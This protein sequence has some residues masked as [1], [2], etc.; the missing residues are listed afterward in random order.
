MCNFF[1]SLRAF[2]LITARAPSTWRQLKNLTL[3]IDRHPNHGKLS[4]LMF[5]SVRNLLSVALIFFTSLGIA[6][7]QVSVD[8]KDPQPGVTSMGHAWEG[9][10]VETWHVQ[11]GDQVKT[12]DL[13]VSLEHDRQLHS[14]E[15]A[16]LQAKNTAPLESV[17]GELKKKEAA[18][19][20][21][22]TRFR[23]RQISEEQL[24]I[25][26]G[27]AAVTRAALKQTNLN[28]E[29]AQ[30]DMEL[31]EKLLE[32][33]YIRSPINGTIVAIA[34]PPGEQ[35]GAG[36]AVVTVS[37]FSTL[38]VEVPLT[39]QAL[40]SLET[41]DNFIL[42][43]GSGGQRLAR[44]LSVQSLPGGAANSRLVKLLFANTRPS[45]PESYKVLLPEGV[46]SAPPAPNATESAGKL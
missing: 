9:G 45:N 15:K 22:E 19:T 6:S 31:A 4:T 16:K 33:R 32:R 7:A 8:V 20:E 29:M 39:G 12:G 37:D 28:R 35:V 11:I 18:L 13:V 17:L 38:A 23:R 10:L 5:F 25:L 41:G 26:E 42:Q 34:H 1:N 30:L 24:H 2:D 27:D 46:E 40:S 14:F 21:G 36:E 44:V 3:S 43:T